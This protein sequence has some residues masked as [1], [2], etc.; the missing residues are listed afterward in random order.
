[1]DLS[2]F[3]LLPRFLFPHCAIAS[4]ILISGPLNLFILLFLYITLSIC[5]LSSV[6]YTGVPCELSLLTEILE[7]ARAS[8]VTGDF[9]F[10]SLSQS[11]MPQ[12]NELVLTESKN[13]SF[14][15]F[16]FLA[17]WP[18]HFQVTSIM[19]KNIC[20]SRD[21]RQHVSDLPAIQNFRFT[22][23]ISHLKLKY[24]SGLW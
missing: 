21:L 2:Q 13:A 24:N 17:I 20:T 3:N 18:H 4:F 22:A 6:F 16:S 14:F 10:S 15:F 23:H 1:M 8:I 19:Q 7:A 9:F 11:K 5:T 12:H